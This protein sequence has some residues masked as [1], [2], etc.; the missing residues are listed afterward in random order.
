MS[1]EVR[2][3]CTNRCYYDSRL[4]HC[5]GCYRSLQ[6]IENWYKMSEEEKRAELK[7]C[8]ERRYAEKKRS[9]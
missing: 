8:K 2:S 4:E 6:S 7:K 1:K 3:P 9:L 5:L